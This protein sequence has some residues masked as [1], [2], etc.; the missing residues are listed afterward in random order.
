MTEMGAV[1]L[2]NLCLMNR[3]A[4]EIFTGQ[5]AVLK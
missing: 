5:G 4:Q 3:A 2:A 1:I